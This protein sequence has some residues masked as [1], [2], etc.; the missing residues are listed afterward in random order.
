[1]SIV[2]GKCI[3]DFKQDKVSVNYVYEKLHVVKNIE[4]TTINNWYI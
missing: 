1:M 4:K 2:I 3:Q